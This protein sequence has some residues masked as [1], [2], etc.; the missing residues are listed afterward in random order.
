[1]ILSVRVDVFVYT[2]K[3]LFLLTKNLEKYM[4]HKQKSFLRELDKEKKMKKR[5]KYK[6]KS[7]ITPPAA[8]IH[9]GSAF[10]EGYNEAHL[11]A[12]AE[13]SLA[14]EEKLL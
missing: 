8:P 4:I 11:Q 10:E 12:F 5:K 7:Y 1:L 13:L 3:T 6:K 9:G 14:V 2:S